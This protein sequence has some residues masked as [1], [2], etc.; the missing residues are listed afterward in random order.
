MSVFVVAMTA[1]WVFAAREAMSYLESR[2]KP[3]KTAA[4]S[5]DPAP[6][7]LAQLKVSF[8]DDHA[9]LI[10]KMERDAADSTLDQDERNARAIGYTS[11]I[12]R[13]YAYLVTRIEDRS[14][15]EILDLHNEIARAARETDE[16]L[17]NAYW[18]QGGAALSKDEDAVPDDLVEKSGARLVAALGDALASQRSPWDEPTEQDWGAFG[19]LLQQGLSEEQLELITTEDYDDPAYCDS[20]IGFIDIL[21]EMQGDAGTRIRAWTVKLMTEG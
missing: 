10:E 6:N 19:S 7:Y 5:G 1:V 3:P 2:T 15:R 8:P 16:S 9:E 12:R 20:M 18:V 14:L 11:E 21:E 17:C 4:R 13:K